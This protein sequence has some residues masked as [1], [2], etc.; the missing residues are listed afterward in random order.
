MPK[1]FRF[2]HRAPRDEP[3]REEIFRRSALEQANNLIVSIYS[4]KS[5][6]VSD[7]DQ[8]STSYDLI[9][10]DLQC[11]V[12]CVWSVQKRLQILSLEKEKHK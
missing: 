2:Q 9:H 8:D 11:A 4:L 5:Q 3:E 12:D 6:V 1:G 7:I 10:K